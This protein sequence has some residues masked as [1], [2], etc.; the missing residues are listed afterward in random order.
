LPR[1]RTS[2]HPPPCSIIV[3]SA[4]R[5]RPYLWGTLMSPLR[6]HTVK[7]AWTCLFFCASLYNDVTVD[8][9]TLAHTA[10]GLI[11]H[12]LVARATV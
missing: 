10:K 2:G 11:R 5:V 12:W 9:L 6:G 7:R 8:R 3:I 1:P 4:L